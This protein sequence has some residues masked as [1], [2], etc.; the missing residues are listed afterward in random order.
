MRTV[1]HHSSLL[2][3]EPLL[4]FLRAAEQQQQQKRRQGA[5]E[6][7]AVVRVLE[8]A[9]DLIGTEINSFVLKSTRANDGLVCLLRA[10]GVMD[11]PY[12]IVLHHGGKFVSE[13][14][15]KVMTPVVGGDRKDDAG[16]A[17]S[18]S[19]G[20]GDRKDVGFD[21]VVRTQMWTLVGARMRAFGSRGLGVST[22]PW[23][24]VTDTR[25]RMSRHLSFDNP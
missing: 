25:E 11:D 14:H 17:M 16:G 23:G 15:L 24:R 6:W 5:G 18:G 3:G 19:M 22:F 4:C 2:L 8:V 20:G 10:C 1:P 13:S 9:E 21:G 7:A 12:T